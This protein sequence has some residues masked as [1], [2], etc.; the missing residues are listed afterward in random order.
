L[1]VGLPGLPAVKV[2]TAIGLA[3]L[4]TATGAL[5]FTGR[6]IR[7]LSAALGALVAI[8]ALA[9]L[10][11]YAFGLDLGIDQ[12]LVKDTASSIAP[13]RPAQ[14]TLIA[15]ALLGLGCIALAPDRP[16]ARSGDALLLLGGG[17]GA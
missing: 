6:R 3:L 4:G 11:E 12:A 15:L 13:G 5:T 8:A 10:V 7:G 2:N 9:T 1:T 14:A 16:I 17:I